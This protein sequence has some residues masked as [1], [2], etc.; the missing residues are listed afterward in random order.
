MKITVITDR[1]GK[2][3]GTAGQSR[4]G[5][6]GAGGPIP[7][8]GEKAHDMELP[9]ALKNIKLPD[10]LHRALEKHLRSARKSSARKS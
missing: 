2:V 5:E 8:P 10:E 6:A 7:G 9:S 3:I 1:R 4:Q